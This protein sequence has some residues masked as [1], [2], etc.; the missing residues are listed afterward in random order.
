MV[1]IALTISTKQRRAS[2]GNLEKRLD[3]SSRPQILH[4][5]VALSV[6]IGRDVVS[7]LCRV[8]AQAN[9]SVERDRAK[10]YRPAVY[11]LFNDLPQANVV[12]LVRAPAV[13]FLE[14][15]LFLFTLIVDED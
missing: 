4:Q 6:D 13:G 14:C 1:R 5:Q 7:D 15:K 12:S 10:P 2:S 11:S 9:P 3:H 8:V